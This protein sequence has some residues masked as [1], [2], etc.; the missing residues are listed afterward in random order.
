MKTPTRF[1]RMRRVVRWALS[2]GLAILLLLAFL[3][4]SRGVSPALADPGT[5][6]VDG[7]TGND[8]GDCQD[9]DFPCQTIGYALT[10]AV[11]D[12]SIWIAEG[13]YLENLE[14]SGLA[15]TL[16]GG[17]T[18]SGS[19]W[20]MDT[21]ETIVD[22]NDADRVFFIHG[23][24]E[25]WLEYLTITGGSAPEAQCWGGGVN[26]TN[27]DVTVRNALIIDNQALCTS[28]MSG[29]GAG[30]GVNAVFDEGPATLAI[31]DSIISNNVAGDHGGAVGTD[32]V[33]VLLTNTL[34][35]G[36]STSSG[37]ASFTLL[38]NSDMTVV[39]STISGNNPQGA[40]A[41]LLQTAAFTMTNSVMWNNAL[42]LQA[43]PTCPSC[44]DVTYSDI[45]GGWSGTGNIDADPMFVDPAGNDFR[46]SLGSPC[47]D[48][49]TDTGAPD[50]DLIL[51]TRPLDGDGDGTATTDMG[52]YESPLYQ[53]YLPLLLK[54]PAVTP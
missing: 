22:G 38:H 21:G 2:P 1:I 23:G 16:R 7:A 6:Y 33:T 46:L 53:I 47:I 19:Q 17:Y 12:D 27:G 44:F 4:I 37:T 40:Q 26:V 28:G 29:G 39:N 30:G 45:E 8:T 36:N 3:W 10:Q 15:V 14:I 50:H 18:V 35:T 5:L 13:T 34:V 31:E 52:A 41:V 48:T 42:N 51:N 11:D 54:S 20:I 9:L 43:D 49:G 32:Q 25:V 24:S